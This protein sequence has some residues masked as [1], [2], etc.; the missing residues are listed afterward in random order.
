MMSGSRY[1]TLARQLMAG[2]ARGDHPVG[3]YLPTEH[4]LGEQYGLSRVTV[5]EALREL[6]QLGLVSRRPRHGTRVESLHPNSGF[7]LVGDSLDAVLRFTQDLPFI[8][9]GSEAVFPDVRQAQEFQLSASQR[10]ARIT[11]VRCRSGDAPTL[12]SEHWIPALYAPEAATLDGLT[13]SIA[14]F[15]ARQRDDEIH[16]I[17]QVIDVARLDR[18]QADALGVPDGS[19]ALRTRRW[20]R[21]QRA[22]LVLMSTSLS[23]EGRYAMASVLQRNPR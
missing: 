1:R 3:S 17:N 20:Y 13:G 18:E 16:R 19:A 23:P 11:G 4:A 14:E 12:F 22:D 10:Y 6:E 9:L 5:R 7:V 15:L 8:L 2:I 21:N